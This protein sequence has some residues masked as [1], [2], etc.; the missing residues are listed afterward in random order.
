VSDPREVKRV[1]ELKAQHGK[2]WPMAWLQEKLPG[3]RQE[4]VGVLANMY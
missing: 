1:A 3:H 2:R 4:W